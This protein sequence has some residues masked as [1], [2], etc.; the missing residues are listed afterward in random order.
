MNDLEDFKREYESLFER[1]KGTIISIKDVA[2]AIN[3][4]YREC[5]KDAQ[6]GIY[7]KNVENVL[8]ELTSPIV[9]Y[10]K[11]TNEICCYIPKE[12]DKVYEEAFVNY[13][14]INDV[15]AALFGYDL[16]MID[17]NFFKMDIGDWLLHTPAHT[18]FEKV[19]REIKPYFLINEKEADSNIKLSIYSYVYAQICR[20][21]YSIKKI[22]RNRKLLLN[23]EYHLKEEYVYMCSQI[24]E[25]CLDLYREAWLIYGENQE[26]ASYLN[27][28]ISP[29]TKEAFLVELGPDARI[30]EWYEKHF[31]QTE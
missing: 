10:N 29:L 13:K 12:T 28:E 19:R 17:K 18:R 11:N 7:I 8:I 9:G 2:E 3:C 4:Q 5:F 30:L 1:K 16:R 23:A 6:P 24:E 27:V 22:R 15:K 21:F 26:D 25:L 14:K 20:H 31:E